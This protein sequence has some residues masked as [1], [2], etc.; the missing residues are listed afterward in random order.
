MDC[1]QELNPHLI[2]IKDISFAHDD[3][4]IFNN[5]NITV[6]GVKL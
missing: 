3:R 5:L 6:K 4:L 1:K 2:T